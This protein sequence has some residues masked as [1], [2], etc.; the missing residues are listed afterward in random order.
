MKPVGKYEKTI[1]DI[2]FD[3]REKNSSISF[4]SLSF[5]KGQILRIL[6]NKIFRCDV[7]IVF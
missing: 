3:V 1:L 6:V 7:A 4:I 2:V 5:Y